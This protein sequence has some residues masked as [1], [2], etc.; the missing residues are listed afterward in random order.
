MPISGRSDGRP[1]TTFLNSSLS[2]SF[3]H[4][5]PVSWYTTASVS[6]IQLVRMIRGWGMFFN[7]SSVIFLSLL[8]HLWFTL[9]SR[10]GLS[11]PPLA[12]FTSDTFVWRN[13]CSFICDFITALIVASVSTIALTL[14][15]ISSVNMSTSG[16]LRRDR[17]SAQK[18]IIARSATSTRPIR[19]PDWGCGGVV[20]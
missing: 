12:S 1:L 7:T 15:P 9:I 6:A 17:G 19:F 14:P 13:Y 4:I 3:T 16:D 10:S 18:E 20:D 2:I 11:M 5:F 8:P